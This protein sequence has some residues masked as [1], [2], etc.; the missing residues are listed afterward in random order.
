VL[1][2]FTKTNASFSSVVT[3]SSLPL[4]NNVSKRLVGVYLFPTLKKEEGQVT[5]HEGRER[6][7]YTKEKGW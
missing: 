7:I 3:P 2:Q 5:L 6:R 1:R 4:S